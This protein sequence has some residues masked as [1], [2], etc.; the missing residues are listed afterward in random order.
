M[1]LHGDTNKSLA[2]YLDLSTASISAK[3][4]EHK[5]EFTK[6]EIDKIITKYSLTASEIKEIFFADKVS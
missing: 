5:T 4:N 1:K 2:K 3:K 6:S